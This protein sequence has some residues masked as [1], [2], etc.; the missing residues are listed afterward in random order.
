MLQIA[1]CDDNIDELSNMVQLIHILHIHKKRAVRFD[2]T[3]IFQQAIADRRK[4]L[5]TFDHLAGA[6]MIEDVSADDLG[7]SQIG[8]QYFLNP[9]I[10]LYDNRI[11]ILFQFNLLQQFIKGEEQLLL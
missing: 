5:R 3:P 9:L 10:A 6:Q 8:D 7:K 4:R 1:V 11:L 2:K